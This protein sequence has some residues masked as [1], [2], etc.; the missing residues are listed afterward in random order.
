[1]STVRQAAPVL[2][3]ALAFSSAS[4]QEPPSTITT[5]ADARA[6]GLDSLFL[7]LREEGVPLPS[8]LGTVVR[9]QTIA[10]RMG[11]ALFF[12]MGVGSDGIQACATC[13]FHAGADSRGRNQASP[14]LV[15][16][17]GQRQGDVLGFSQAM[18]APDETF[19][20]RPPNGMLVRGDFPFVRDIGHG[21]NVVTVNGVQEPAPGNSNDV[22]SSQGIHLTD[23]VSV[24][25]GALVDQGIPRFDPVFNA[26]GHT[27]RRVEPRNTPTMINAVLN[28]FNFWDGR[29]N[30]YFNGINP[31]GVQDPDA[32]IFASQGTTIVRERLLLDNASLASQAVGPPLSHFEMSFG[33]GGA[34]ARSFPELGRKLLPLQALSIQDVSSTDSL[35]ANLRHP[36][37]KGLTRNYAEFVRAAFHPRYWN[38]SKM[39]YFPPGGQPL[40][41]NPGTTDPART[42][43]LM[44]ANF[45][46]FYGVAVMLY[47]RT[48]ISDRAPFDRWMEGSGAAVPQFGS[49]ELAGLNVFVGKGKCVNCHGGPEFTNASIRNSRANGANVVEPMLMGDHRAAFYDNGFYNIGITPTLDDLGRGGGNPFGQPLASSRQ[50]LFEALDIQEI[51]FEIIGD[52]VRE[53]VEQGGVLGVHDDVTGDFIPVCRDL[54]GDG[55]CGTEDDILLER[56]AVDG[57]F[58]TPG[59]R[60]VS[61][62]GPYFH[63]G[64]MATLMEVVEFYDRGGNFCRLN[65][66]DL[67]PDIQ[68]IGLSLAEKQAL[69]AFLISLTDPRVAR[70]SQPFDHPQLLVPNGSLPDGTDILLDLAAIGRNGRAAS[71]AIVPFLNADPFGANPVTGELDEFGDVACSPDFQQ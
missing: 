9:D 10:T 2:L 43:T 13:H 59:L 29:A 21:D 23:F 31:F 3:L 24:T 58:K 11:K 50:F 27:V 49:R 17:K 8:N 33:D 32:R 63:N 36:S 55:N 47:E 48:L 67:D 65:R 30:P 26:N 14:G 42:F 70:E 64:S 37:G 69:V 1:M 20:V 4:A 46:L 19:E 45:S 66:A 60:N 12:E 57:A 38:S 7:R 41:V 44:E 61:L 51:P 39:V 22:A 6:H 71:Q 62:T 53:L 52:P 5:P 15:R 35:L 28:L 68:P 54:D 40:V 34:N 56:V 18:A 16:S 25:P